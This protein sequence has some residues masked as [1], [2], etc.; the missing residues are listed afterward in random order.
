MFPLTLTVLNRDIIVP[1]GV[2]GL[3]LTIPVARGRPD[4]VQR[5]LECY[6]DMIRVCRGLGFRGQTPKLTTVRGFRG[7]SLQGVRIFFY[8]ESE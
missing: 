2:Q 1:P 3:T 5:K 8:Q 6:L 4:K 7:F